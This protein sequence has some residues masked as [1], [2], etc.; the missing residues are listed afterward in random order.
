[1]IMFYKLT[2]LHYILL[3]VKIEKSLQRIEI[4]V[5]TCPDVTNFEWSYINMLLFYGYTFYFNFPPMLRPCDIYPVSY[6]FHM[7]YAAK[8]AKF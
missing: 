3:F 7:I 2:S 4:N 8:K 1:M 6:H 5:Y